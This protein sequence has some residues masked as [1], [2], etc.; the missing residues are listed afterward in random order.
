MNVASG[1]TESQ[2]AAAAKGATL[3]TEPQFG[4]W[5]A[6]TATQVRPLNASAVKSIGSKPITIAAYQDLVAHRYSD[7]LPGSKYDDQGV[8][9]GYDAGHQASGYQDAVAADGHSPI[10]PIALVG[11]LLAGGVLL[12]VR[13]SPKIR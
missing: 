3:F 1:N 12:V 13:R 4:A 8:A 9:G 11:G 10:V 5:Y 7:K 6:L 2:M